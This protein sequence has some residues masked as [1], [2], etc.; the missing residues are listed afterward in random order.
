M[1][2]I[3]RRVL[4]VM[5]AVVSIAIPA[6]KAVYYGKTVG[7]GTALQSTLPKTNCKVDA[8]G[9]AGDSLRTGSYQKGSVSPGLLEAEF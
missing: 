5:L 3:V 1:F 9:K 6:S 2:R 8:P 7:T 4:L